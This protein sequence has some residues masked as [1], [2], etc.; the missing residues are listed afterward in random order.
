M[1][2]VSQD[3]PAVVPHVDCA[4]VILPAENENQKKQYRPKSI[5]GIVKGTKGPKGPPLTYLPAWKDHFGLTQ[6]ELAELTGLCAASIAHIERGS[7]RKPFLTTCN[8]IAKALSEISNQVITV[9]DL[10]NWTPEQKKLAEQKKVQ[11]QEKQTHMEEPKKEIVLVNSTEEKISSLRAFQVTLGKLS[12]SL[13]MAS[14]IAPCPQCYGIPS[15]HQYWVC[16]RCHTWLVSGVC[17]NCQSTDHVQKAHAS[18]ICQ[19]EGEV[20]VL[21]NPG[22][23]QTLVFPVGRVK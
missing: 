5:T 22:V 4:P 9:D 23:H 20:L 17:P 1:A 13:Q 15:T 7:T 8:K 18:C 19:G 21:S 11:L 3:I 16:V 12:P 10:A 14:F 2:V 6:D